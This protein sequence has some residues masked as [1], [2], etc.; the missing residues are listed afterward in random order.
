MPMNTKTILGLLRVKHYIKNLFIFI[1]V[2]FAGKVEMATSVELALAFLSFSMAASTIYI[3]NDVKDILADREHPV[4]KFRPIPAGLV[5]I[6]SAYIISF[7]TLLIAL[8][9]G[10]NLGY[11][12]LFIVSSYIVLNIFYSYSWKHIAIL[13]VS[14]ISCGFLLRVFLGGVAGGVDISRWLII[15]VFLL[16]LGL[17]FGKRYD[18]VLLTEGGIQKN[19]RKSIINYS[20]VFLRN[21]IV[22]VFTISTV[23]YLLY[24]MNIT[25]E[26]IVSSKNFYLTSFPV[27]IGILRYLAIIFTEEKS[28]SPTEV[29]LNDRFLQI[30]LLIWILSILYFLYFNAQAI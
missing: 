11:L 2:F 5:S 24:S 20:A 9:C 25:G 26:N 14:I 8:F 27:I 15:M 22:T 17:A 21:A 23:C 16:S 6:R 1:P 3:W 18:D 29:L 28:G 12:A 10:Y 7:A 30:S 13:D 4:K 19:I